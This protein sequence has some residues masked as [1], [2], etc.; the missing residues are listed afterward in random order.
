M[1]SLLKI[2]ILLLLPFSVPAQSPKNK[3]DSLHLALKNATNDTMRMNAYD[4]L[5]YYYREVNWDSALYYAEIEISIAGKLKLALDEARLLQSKGYVLMKLGNYSRSMEAFLQAIKI[6]ENP[7]S[8]KNILDLSK[9]Q[10]RRTYRLEIL[11]WNYL[12]FGHLYINTGNPG[13]AI[14]WY[15]EAKRIS[16]SINDSIAPALIY[17]NLGST[18]LKLNKL[19][20]A[21]LFANMAL[22]LFTKVKSLK[23]HKYKGAAFNNIGKI[24]QKMGKN[25]LAHDYFYKAIQINQKR[26]NL[27]SLADSYLSLS[28]LYRINKQ[29]DSSIIYAKKSLLLVHSLN[30][31]LTIADAYTSLSLAYKEKN[32]LDSSYVYLN[33][34]STLKDSLNKIKI[35]KLN[36]FMNVGF[37]EQMHIGELEKEKIK[38]QGRIRT[39]GLLGGIG[40]FLIIV[41]LLYRNNKQKQKVN[42]VLEEKNT[43][44]TFEKTRSEELL[45]NILPAQVAEELKQTGHCQ[46]KTFS[47][48]T[49]MFMDF[50]DFTTVGEKISAELL[51]DQINFCFSAFD[52]IIQKYKVEKIKTVGDAYICVGGLPELNY[53]HALDVVTAATE[54]RNFMLNHKKDKESKGEIPFELRIGIHTGPVVAGIV[55]VK[56]F[57]YDIWGDTVNLAARMEQTSEAGKINISGSTYKLVEEKFNCTYRGKIEAKNKGE[58]EMYFVERMT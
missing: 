5:H 1:N 4:Q 43:I 26:T 46:A 51:V 19:D 12:E 14:S 6:S 22:E 32:Y 56:K 38:T 24:Y 50:K 31:P 25:E 16:E 58:V 3:P 27:N 42:K 21:L 20:S 55:G 41:F 47:M 28:N 49:V 36:E 48:V 18:Y 53:T 37:N 15:L 30:T 44:I 29:P 35:Q 39:Y 40:I 45:L 2:V 11:E 8:E 23:E 7:E 52:G 17:L 9:N 34:A 33:L 13:K 54:I 10:T 57:Q